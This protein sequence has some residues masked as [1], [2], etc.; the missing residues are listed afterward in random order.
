MTAEVRAA[1][2]RMPTLNV[3]VVQDGAPEMWTLTRDDL[4]ALQRQLRFGDP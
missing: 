2:R 1:K 4:S 3:A